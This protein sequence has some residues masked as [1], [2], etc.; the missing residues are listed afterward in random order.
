M[1][2]KRYT[3]RINYSVTADLAL[4]AA[5]PRKALVLAKSIFTD[6]STANQFQITGRSL[7]ALETT[8]GDRR[9]LAAKRS[10]AT[11]TPLYRGIPHRARASAWTSSVLP[12]RSASKIIARSARAALVSLAPSIHYLTATSAKANAPRHMDR[13][14]W[15]GDLLARPVNFSAVGKWSRC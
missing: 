6:Q 1:S 10:E 14:G 12:S 3:A 2:P 13:D 5:S 11:G 4:K 7:H 9:Q 15:G 8:V